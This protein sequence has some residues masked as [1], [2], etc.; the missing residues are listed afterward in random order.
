[1]LQVFDEHVATSLQHRPLNPLYP[2]V[3]TD[4]LLTDA[5]TQD[6]AQYVVGTGWNIM[7]SQGYDMR[8]KVT[9]FHSLWGQQHFKYSNMEEHI[10][11][12]GVQ[13]V[14]FYFLD[15]PEEGC[16]LVLHDPRPGKIQISLPEEDISKITEATNSIVFDAKPGTLFFTNSWLPHSFTRNGSDKPVK[17]IHMN[18]SVKDDPNPVVCQDAPVIV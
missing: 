7:K 17:F 13:L 3:M 15:V 12:D 16:K 18:I 1:V 4:N 6:F 9:Y 14:G 10:H 8:K 2:S 5:R 11:N